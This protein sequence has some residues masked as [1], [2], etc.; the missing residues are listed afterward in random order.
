MSEKIRDHC[1]NPLCGKAIEPI[2]N[3]WRRSE[4]LYCGDPCKQAASLIRRV[5]ALYSLPVAVMH[6]ALRI[7]AETRRVVS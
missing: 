7:C 4:R 5:A 6:D 1:E 2:D 3:G